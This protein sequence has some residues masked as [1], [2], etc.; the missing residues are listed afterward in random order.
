MP[1]RLAFDLTAIATKAVDIVQRD[2]LRFCSLE[3]PD[4]R[5]RCLHAGVKVSMNFTSELSRM[6]GPKSGVEWLCCDVDR[7]TLT[8]RERSIE[9]MRPA[10]Q[11]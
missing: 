4:W 3:V 7:L 10:L 5:V 11:D 2:C 9:T 6:T 1:K 8:I